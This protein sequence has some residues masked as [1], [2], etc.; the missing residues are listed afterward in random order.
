MGERLDERFDRLDRRVDERDRR[1]DALE[2]NLRYEIRQ[3]QQSREPQHHSG[4]NG[5]LGSTKIIVTLVQA[6]FV[7]IM[8]VIAIGALAIGHP[9]LAAIVTGVP[10]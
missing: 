7:L 5:V 10:K 1:L 6:V 8:A 2:Q 3:A 9:E 4:S